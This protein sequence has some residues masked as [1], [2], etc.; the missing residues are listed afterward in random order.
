M[1]Y[2]F[3]CIRMQC[4]VQQCSAVMKCARGVACVRCVISYHSIYYT[5]MN[6]CIRRA[7]GLFARTH[8]RSRALSCT[9]AGRV[10]GTVA[11][12][13]GVS[14]MVEICLQYGTRG[15][16]TTYQDQF[17]SSKNN[18]TD[19]PT[20]LSPLNVPFR[21][22]PIYSGASAGKKMWAFSALKDFGRIKVGKT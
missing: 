7:Q 9:P 15:V 3:L 6:R 14:K 20:I 4:P 13:Q 12:V 2:A 21:C 8:A 16:I 22:R 17:Y 19:R 10:H 5:V 1:I 18:R 11:L